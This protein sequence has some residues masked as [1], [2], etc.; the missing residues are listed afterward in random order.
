MQDFGALD[1]LIDGFVPWK[2][3]KVKKNSRLGETLNID[4]YI[5]PL[6]CSLISRLCD[7]YKISKRDFYIYLQWLR[8]SKEY[9]RYTMW[10]QINRYKDKNK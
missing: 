2:M 4:I 9:D 3:R 6:H 1:C 5:S 10:N 7:Y 8:E